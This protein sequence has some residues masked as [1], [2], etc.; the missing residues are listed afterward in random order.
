MKKIIAILILALVSIGATAQTAAKVYTRK[1]KLADFME[2]PTMFVLTGSFFYDRIFRD[3]VNDKWE[4]TAFEFISHEEY[5]KIKD[6]D[7]YYFVTSSI[8]RYPGEEGNGVRVLDVVSGGV[9]ANGKKLEIVTVPVGDGGELTEANAFFLPVLIEIMQ[10]Y[11]THALEHETFAYGRLSSLAATN[12]MPK[13][14]ELVTDQNEAIEA[15]R[16]GAEGK[17]AV[18]EIVSTDPTPGVSHAYEM[19]IGCADHTLYY[20]KDKKIRK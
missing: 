3:A 13:E 15:I 17:V 6:K 19:H 4:I 12:K 8:M 1:M 14:M 16:T 11:I 18:Y 5:L 10:T 20:Y 2:K 9:D 7:E